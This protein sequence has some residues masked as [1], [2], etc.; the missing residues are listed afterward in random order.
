MK[1]TDYELKEYNL[2]VRDILLHMVSIPVTI[3]TKCLS[4]KDT[5]LYIEANQKSVITCGCERGLDLEESVKKEKVESI[6]KTWSL[7][8]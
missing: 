8:L 5:G 7:G 3:L 4:C 6:L 2:T 1:L